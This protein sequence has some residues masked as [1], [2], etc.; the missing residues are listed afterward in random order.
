[1][2]APFHGLI[3][4]P[5]DEVLQRWM[6]L[7]RVYLMPITPSLGTSPVKIHLELA[8]GVGWGVV[9]QGMGCRG[10]ERNGE[11]A[12]FN[13]MI[14]ALP[15]CFGG[16]FFCEMLKKSCLEGCRPLHYS[17]SHQCWACLLS[18]GLHLGVQ[19]VQ[20]APT[21]SSTHP[22]VPGRWEVQTPPEGSHLPAASPIIPVKQPLRLSLC[23]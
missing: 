2:F 16:V 6:L 21:P 8:A 19:G 1:M 22:H 11:M 5:E 18:A 20:G 13:S 14:I 3:P 12:R 23:M 4:L 9:G 17:T 7:W 10:C 15:V